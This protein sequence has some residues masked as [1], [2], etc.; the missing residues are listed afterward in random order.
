MSRRCTYNGREIPCS[1]RSSSPIEQAGS[2]SSLWKE[3]H[4][5]ALTESPNNEWLITWEK[6]VKSSLGNCSCYAQW[7]KLRE[8]NPI[9]WNN[10]F[11]WTVLVHNLVNKKLGKKE[12]TAE[13]AKQLYLYL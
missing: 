8:Q 12:L 9:N 10:L 3:L 4:I 7:K 5:W 1:P 11:E 6:K 13:E 2:G